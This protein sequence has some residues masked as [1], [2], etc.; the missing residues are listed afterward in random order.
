MAVPPVAR[1]M[2][3]VTCL[4]PVECYAV[5]RTGSTDAN[6]HGLV[7]R[8][9]NGHDWTVSLNST[10]S[11]VLRSIACLS[12]AWCTAVGGDKSSNAVIFTLH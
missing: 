10:H 1:T 9:T 5:G 6:G 3:G 7:L 4:T 11:S 8:T 2:Y 12:P